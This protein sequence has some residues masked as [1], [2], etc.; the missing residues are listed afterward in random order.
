M[1][2]DILPG[3]KVQTTILNADGT[4]RDPADEDFDFTRDISIDQ[5]TTTVDP[6]NNTITM[7]GHVRSLPNAL[8]NID[9]ITG[10][11]LELRLNAPF[12]WDVTPE[13]PRAGRSDLRAQVL[14]ADFTA[15]GDNDPTT[16]RHVFN[17]TQ[18]DV[19]NAGDLSG[20]EQ[21]FEWSALTADAPP[22]I[23]VFS[24]DANGTVL[25]GCP[26]M[27]RTALTDVSTHTVAGKPVVNSNNVANN[28]VVGGVANGAQTVSVQIPG[29]QPQEGTLTPVDP[30]NPN[31]NQTWTATIPT[32]E[33]Q[34]LQQ[35]Q[36]NI[37][38]S[39]TGVGVPATSTLSVLK[40]TVNPAAPTAD[41]LPGRYPTQQFVTLDG[42]DFPTGAQIRYR[43]G[44]APADPTATTGTLYAGE[45]IVA[46]PPGPRTIKAIVIDSAGNVSP[47]ASFTYTFGAITAPGAP[48][49]RN[50]ATAGNTTATVN[51]TAPTDNGGRAIT[52]YRVRAFNSA[53]TLVT[54][55]NVTG[56][57]GGATSAQV[58]G[59]TNGTA[60][61]FKVS[62][63]NTPDG[64]TNVWGAESAFS[65]TVTPTAGGGG[66][67]LGAPTIGT[68]D[69]GVAG[70]TVSATARWTPPCNTCGIT[71]YLVT[72]VR[73]NATTGT[74]LTPEQTATMTAGANAITKE[75]TT[76][77]I[78]SGTLVS[79][80]SYKFK[81]QASNTPTGQPKQY[82]SASA[83]SNRVVAR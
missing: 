1:T 20:I 28:M 46:A 44:S 78:N 70:G 59:L 21:I 82:G 47:V 35:G 79:G 77:N 60:Y 17:V 48:T 15:D 75:M 2:P 19:T 5:G 64:Q 33:L 4:P 9:D 37:T 56:I 51:W 72:A 27:A 10:D 55:R 26:P 41:P 57:P 34:A 40:D 16:F 67:Q 66:T 53:G 30:A 68:A 29:G 69:S 25:A 11:V 8:I 32:S 23:T 24:G 13:N 42:D 49:I 36:F 7:N 38:A 31:G 50:D 58:T 45:Q 73:V 54:G 39:F 61:K 43:I 76:A 80:A 18:N 62:A 65:N 81:V 83:L 6:A 74:P 3:D 14:E 22:T 12:D 52:E 71:G 63:S